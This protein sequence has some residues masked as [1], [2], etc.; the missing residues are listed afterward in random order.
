ML[1]K[2]R[3]TTKVITVPPET[4]V[5]EA[6]H[7]M[8]KHGIRRLPVVDPDGCLIGI[9]TDRDL[10]QVLIPWKSSQKD[11]EFY[12]LASEVPVRDVMTDNVLTISPHTDVADAARIIYK[13][14]IGGLPVIDEDRKVVGIITEMDLL[15]MFIEIMGIIGASSR[16]DVILGED[17]KA[18]EQ[19]SKILRDNGGEIISVG[20]SGAEEDRTEKV[21]FFR[22][23]PCDTTLILG[24]LKEA[25]F[26][27]VASA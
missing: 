14:K 13:H 10:R 22:L 27:V 17:P 26:S 3:M 8:K 25:G 5:E 23:E 6:Y 1:V 7:L 15:A 2:D 12:Y 21:Y 20:M 16:I 4:D 18:F 11:K 19:V 24:A 9:V